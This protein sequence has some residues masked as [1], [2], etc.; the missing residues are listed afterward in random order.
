MSHAPIQ[1]DLT[2]SF[3]HVSGATPFAI[4]D[5]DATFQS[6][7]NGMVKFVHAKL[8]GNVLNVELINKDIYA[9]LEEAAIE[10]GAVVNSYHAKSV[11]A[12]ILGSATGSLSG[13]EQKNPRLGLDLI[14]RRAE[15]YSSEALV[16]GNRT[17][18]SAS[19]S[20]VTGVQHYDLKVLLSSSGKILNGERAELREVFHFSPTAAYRFFDTTSAVNYLHNEFSFESFTSETIWYLLPTWEDTLRAQQLELSHRIRRS[21]YSYNIVNN[22]LS[23]F[24]VPTTDTTLYLKYFKISATDN[25]FDSSSDPFV[26]GVSSLNNVPFGNINYSK[27]NSI[28]RSWIRRFALSLAKELLGQIRSKMQSIPIPNGDLILNGPELVANAREEQTSLR[29]EIRSLFDSMTYDNLAKSETEQAEA[30]MRQLMKIPL[31]IFVGNLLIYLMF[32][33]QI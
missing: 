9:C 6:D 5:S 11:L 17:L 24:P 20:L 8:G 28:G 2:A 33:Q 22:V 19:I 25:I 26:D 3:V 15:A 32:S 21:N 13:N 12:D 30:I 4:Y 18:H 10:Y 31:P 23:I 14:K 27:I 29:D 7:A 1:L 16:G